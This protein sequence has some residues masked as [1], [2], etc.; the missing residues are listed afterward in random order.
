MILDDC[1]IGVAQCPQHAT[2]VLSHVESKDKGQQQ[3]RQQQHDSGPVRLLEYR[4]QR[5]MFSHKRGTFVPVPPVVKGFT[6][7]LMRAALA[8]SSSSF[9][10]A[11]TGV[12][13]MGGS[14]D[15]SSWSRAYRAMQ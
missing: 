7:E 9:G 14:L 12:V 11:G 4:C 10:G 5:F 6:E 8:I 3:R 2:Q 15:A 13:G 1:G